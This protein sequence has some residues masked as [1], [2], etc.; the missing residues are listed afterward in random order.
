MCWYCPEP[1]KREI[2][3]PTMV[4]TAPS[5]NTM[6]LVTELPRATPARS[7]SPAC[8]ATMVS[9]T[10]MPTYIILAM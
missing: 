5:E 8:P 9:I 1:R 7:L 10:P 3:G 6:G 4:S 2:M